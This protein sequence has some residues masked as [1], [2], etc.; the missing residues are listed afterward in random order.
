MTGRQSETDVTAARPEEAGRPKEAERRDPGIG[1][2]S[3]D[4]RAG[5]PLH[6]ALL[7]LLPL[8]GTWR[9]AGTGVVPSTG[10]QF[11]YRQNVIFGHDGR[12]FLAY[13]SRT[14]LVDGA[15]QVIRPALRETG[16]WRPG[17]GQDDIEAQI[18]T[19]TGLAIS[20]LGVAGDLRWEL[21]STGISPTPTAR[22]VDG[23]RRLYA[24]V[25]EELSYVTEVAPV[26]RDYA[27]HLN[28]K[29]HRI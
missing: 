14:V 8:V 24:L 29:L 23:E 4:L 3:T 13:D 27:P 19:V 6:D 21:A 28:A 25:G 2:D 7:A 9:G 22:A 10:E 15:G 20:Y 5:A 12:P 16:F 11:G 17:R 1:A 18:V 26:G